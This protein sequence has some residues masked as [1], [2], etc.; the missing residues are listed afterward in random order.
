LSG[1]VTLE[2]RVGDGLVI[3]DVVVT[4]NTTGDEAFGKEIGATLLTFAWPSTP[5]L[6]GAVR[7]SYP[8]EFAPQPRRWPSSR[9]CDGALERSTARRMSME[10]S[11]TRPLLL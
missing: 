2:F 8:F 5:P 3:D 1:T 11:S 10:G 4:G 9:G 6:G 7:F